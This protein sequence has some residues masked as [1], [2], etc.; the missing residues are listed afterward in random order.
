MPRGLRLALVVLAVLLS[1]ALG[2]AS[3]W[4]HESAA[5]RV[6]AAIKAG[7]ALAL[8]H[9]GSHRHAT[10]ESEAART[11]PAARRALHGQHPGS[12]RLH[13]AASSPCD[14]SRQSDEPCTE[15]CCNVACHAVADLFVPFVTAPPAVPIA[16]TPF[17]RDGALIDYR[18][19][20]ERPPRRSAE[21]A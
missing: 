5:P 16:A 7:E 1:S 15:S 17:V 12:S 18:V 21:N 9:S 20:F 4:A 6:I 10:T 13:G 3:T 19:P 11:A 8:H 14:P 2:M